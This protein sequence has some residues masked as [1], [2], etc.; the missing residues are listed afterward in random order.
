M[1]WAVAVVSDLW[2]VYAYEPDLLDGAR[3]ELYGYR[4]SIVHA[5]YGAV[6]VC[7]CGSR[8]KVGVGE[9]R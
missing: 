4:V 9:F 5:F 6:E 3:V 8:S 1:G 2:G 7:G